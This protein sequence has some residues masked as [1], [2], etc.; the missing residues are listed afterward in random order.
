M[1]F[2]TTR[3][4]KISLYLGVLGSLSSL[5]FTRP[6]KALE[7]PK[8]NDILTHCK[9]ME[10]SIVVSKI[11]YTELEKIGKDFS[12]TYRMKNLHVYY[13]NPDKIRIETSSRVYGDALLILNGTKRYYAVSKLN[14][15]KMEDLD[16]DS[17]KRQSLLEYGGQMSEGTLQFMTATFLKEESLEDTPTLV[18]ELKYKT[19]VPA[20]SYLVWVDPKTRLTL[21]RVWRDKDGKVKATFLYSNPKEIGEGVWVPGHCEIKNAEGVF[22]AALDFK[23]AKVVSGLDTGLFEI[24]L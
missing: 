5:L 15:R 13:Q 6:L 1:K 4:Q 7:N 3:Q 22:S 12:A 18:F 19:T 21:K 16:K 11:D 9:E 8:A 2:G 23:E 17:A 14:L 24:K 20:S 10:A